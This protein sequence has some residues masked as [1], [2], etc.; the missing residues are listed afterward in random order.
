MSNKQFQLTDE[1]ILTS[2]NYNQKNIDS[3]RTKITTN[4]ASRV[5][6]NLCVESDNGPETH[7]TMSE[8]SSSGNIM[9]SDSNIHNNSKFIVDLWD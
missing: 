8:I 1:E 5:I 2:K 9:V 3:I 6:S 7:L 4:N